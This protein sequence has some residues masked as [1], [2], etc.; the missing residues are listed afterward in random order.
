MGQRRRQRGPGHEETVVVGQT[1]E[2][3]EQ[4]YREIYLGLLANGLLDGIGSAGP[5]KTGHAEIE[6]FK[7]MLRL[8]RDHGREFSGHFD[9]ES[10]GRRFIYSLVNDRRKRSIA[11]LSQR[12]YEKGVRTSDRE[13]PD[14]EE[15]SRRLVGVP[16]S[17]VQAS[18]GAARLVQ[19]GAEQAAG[20]HTE[21]QLR[22]QDQ[23]ADDGGAVS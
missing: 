11:Y 8:Y 15:T 21:D 1:L 9:L 16:V 14:E 17:D 12:E 20:A 13:R 22:G 18:L 10:I 19:E 7:V 23:R 5:G 3:R 2:Q 6:R 4:V